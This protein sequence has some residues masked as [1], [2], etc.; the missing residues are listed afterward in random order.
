MSS[1]S[2]DNGPD[3]T[4]AEIQARMM[5]RMDLEY[6]VSRVNLCAWHGWACLPT[7]TVLSL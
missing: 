3:S 2:S 5:L 1:P 7:S 4:E 6:Q